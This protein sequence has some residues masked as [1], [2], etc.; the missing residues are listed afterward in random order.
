M[1]DETGQMEIYVQ[2]NPPTGERWKISNG[3]GIDPLWSSDGKEIFFRTRNQWIS[4]PVET[5]SGFHYDRQ[6]VLFEGYY[7]D[8]GGKSFAVS[9]DGQKF[10]LLKPVNYKQKTQELV[11]IENWFEQL[12]SK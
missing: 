3:N 11:V 8:V 9:R 4:V 5:D 10:L 12:K 7:I 2:P 6:K 1:S